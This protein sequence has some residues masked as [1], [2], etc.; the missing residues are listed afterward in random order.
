MSKE[1]FRAMPRNGRIGEIY[2]VY[3]KLDTICEFCYPSS[4]KEV[5]L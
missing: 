4:V 2:S 5:T 3:T 1:A